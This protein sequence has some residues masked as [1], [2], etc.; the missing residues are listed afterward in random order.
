MVETRAM[1]KEAAAFMTPPPQAP[2][3][4]LTDITPPGAPRVRQ[5]LSRVEQAREI[6]ERTAEKARLALAAAAAALAP[7]EVVRSARKRAGLKPLP[8]SVANAKP[9]KAKKPAVKAGGATKPG[10]KPAAKPA[11][12]PN[13]KPSAQTQSELNAALKAV[14]AG[15]V[16]LA[17]ETRQSPPVWHVC[18]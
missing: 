2:P 14:K 3:R 13:A 1:A 18:A 10:A 6:I 5:R 11:A 7:V 4:D 8:A 9:L 17:A 12:K 16:E 15:S